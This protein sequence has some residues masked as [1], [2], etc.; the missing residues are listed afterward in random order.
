VEIRCAPDG[1]PRQ[2]VWVQGLDFGEGRV[3]EHAVNLGDSALAILRNKAAG[4]WEYVYVT[5]QG[6]SEVRLLPDSHMPYLH[7]SYGVFGLAA[8]DNGTC[9]LVWHDPNDG[10]LYYQALR[11]DAVSGL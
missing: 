11:R 1:K 2:L 3:V 9:H 10:K 7:D 5:P 4:S 6:A 8:S